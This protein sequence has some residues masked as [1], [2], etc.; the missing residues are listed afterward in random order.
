MNKMINLTHDEIEQKIMKILYSNLN[1]FF[2]KYAIYN[3]LL[4]DL[5]YD[6]N[7]HLTT[8][9]LKR[10]FMDVLRVI[11]LKYNNLTIDKYNGYYSITTD[12][13][14]N[15]KKFK[16]LENLHYNFLQTLNEIPQSPS[17]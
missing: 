5:N 6:K 4:D 1:V 3:K 17:N 9:D 7:K 8:T 12:E 16:D 13:K 2:T 14:I 10:K 11:D 15:K